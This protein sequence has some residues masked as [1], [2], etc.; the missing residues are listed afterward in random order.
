MSTNYKEW[1]GGQSMTVGRVIQVKMRHGEKCSTSCFIMNFRFV[2]CRKKSTQPMKQE[3]NSRFQLLSRSLC[4]NEIL[5]CG[6]TDK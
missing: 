4:G 2:R 3:V 6:V 5:S 1:I